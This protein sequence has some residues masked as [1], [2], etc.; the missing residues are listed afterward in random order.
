MS[1]VGPRPPV[2]REVA[3]YTLAD[4]R[5]LDAIPGLTYIW[6]VSGRGDIAFPEQVELD[7]QYIQ[8]QKLWFDILLLIKS[9]PVVFFRERRILILWKLNQKPNTLKRRS[10]RIFSNDSLT[11]E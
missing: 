11:A 9:I 5:R 10:D 2:P 4:R 1:L 7:V 6:Q 3:L 8:S